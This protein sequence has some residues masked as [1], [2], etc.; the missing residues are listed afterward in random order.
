MQRRV[1]DEEQFTCEKAGRGQAVT[2]RLCESG[3]QLQSTISF[4]TDLPIER[5]C[6]NRKSRVFS[7]RKREVRLRRFIL[8]FTGNLDTFFSVIINSFKQ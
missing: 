7:L 8:T 1:R 2:D 5:Y 3:T 6:D 4:L